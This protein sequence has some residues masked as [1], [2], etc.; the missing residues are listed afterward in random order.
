MAIHTFAITD[1]HASSSNMTG[2]FIVVEMNIHIQEICMHPSNVLAI[3]V[4]VLVSAST[5]S[6]NEKVSVIKSAVGI[7]DC[8]SNQKVPQPILGIPINECR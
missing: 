6:R 3:K 5:G 2:P 4:V 1:D 8:L 7:R